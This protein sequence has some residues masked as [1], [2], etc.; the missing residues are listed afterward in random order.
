MLRALRVP[1]LLSLLALILLP[2]GAF[3]QA[4]IAGVVKD[5]SGAG[6]AGRDRRGL[7]PRP[8]REDPF[9]RD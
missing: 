6:T 8:N 9:G 1:V 7:E 3:A 4:S 2:S 5:S